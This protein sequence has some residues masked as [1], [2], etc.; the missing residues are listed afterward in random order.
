MKLENEHGVYGEHAGK[1][2]IGPY[3]KVTVVDDDQP[4]RKDAIKLNQ[5]LISH[6]NAY[7]GKRIEFNL[8]DDYSSRNSFHSVKDDRGFEV[9]FE[10]TPRMPDDNRLHQ[11]P[12]SLGS[13]ELYNVA[14][15]GNR[16]PAKIN[17]V[18][19]VFLPMWQREAMWLNF[20]T[21]CR[22]KCAVRVFVGRVNAISGAKMEEDPNQSSK[23]KVQDYIM[24]PEQHWLDGICVAAGVVRQFVAM[25][26]K[27]NLIYLASRVSIYVIP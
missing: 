2:V 24:L 8:A 9:S 16:L 4:T 18:G 7:Y 11:L 19:G 13:Y 23:N 12:G 1:R 20:T 3:E 14:A 15:F 6:S 17:E 25:P 22:L 10:R 27:R 5:M 21:K 26:C